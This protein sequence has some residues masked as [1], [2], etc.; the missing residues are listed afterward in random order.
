MRFFFL[1]FYMMVWVCE[2]KTQLPLPRFVSIKAGEARL[3]VGPGMQ[4][5]T[6]WVYLRKNLP[7]QIIEEYDTWR[8]IRDMEGYEGWF[9]KSLVQGKRT[10]IIQSHCSL[11][12]SSSEDA[13]I[14]AH[15]EKGVIVFLKSY[16][17]D[18]AYVY[19]DGHKGYVKRSH[20]YGLLPHEVEGK[21]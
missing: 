18:W 12:T 19:L 14:L 13:R 3:H 17:L 16:T 10:L 1:F 8:K 5:P 7:V 4:Y 21:V 2:S 6:T 11:Y 9:H 15:I 20:I